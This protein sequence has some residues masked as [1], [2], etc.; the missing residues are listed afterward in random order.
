MSNLD[1]LKKLIKIDLGSELMLGI[2]LNGL[3]LKDV[4][5]PDWIKFFLIEAEV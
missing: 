3:V 2:L 5:R 4:H 1:F